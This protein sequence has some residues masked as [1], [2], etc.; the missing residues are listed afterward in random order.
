MYTDQI[1]KVP[2]EG[3]VEEVAHVFFL[4]ILSGL[5][6]F[7]LPRSSCSAKRL[8]TSIP[9]T[10]LFRLTFIRKACVIGISSPKTFCLM[11]QGQSRYP[12]SVFARCTN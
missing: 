8:L 11:P 1:T 9:Q 2:D 6:A 3:V 7:S 4:Q 10:P 12:T 5:V